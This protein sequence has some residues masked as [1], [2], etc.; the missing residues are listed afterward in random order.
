MI[1]AALKTEQ[2]VK[3]WGNGLGIRITGPLAK[4]AHLANGVPVTVE[5]DGDALIVR[6][7]GRPKLSLADR[8]KLF[9]PALHGGEAMLSGRVG[10]EVF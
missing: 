7:V 1:T 3:A 10:A 5:F 2:T 6:P 8:L 4:A 9:N